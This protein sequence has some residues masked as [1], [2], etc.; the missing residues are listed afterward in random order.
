MRSIVLENLYGHQIDK[1]KNFKAKIDGNAKVHYRV[2][3]LNRVFD[4]RVYTV[5]K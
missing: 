4:N 1:S 5:P 3:F 2:L